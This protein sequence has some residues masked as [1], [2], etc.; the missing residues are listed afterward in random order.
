M[1]WSEL[2]CILFWRS[3]CWTTSTARWG[4][5]MFHRP[6]VPRIR[7][8]CRDTSIVMEFTSGSGETT[9]SFDAELKLQRSPVINLC[10]LC[11]TKCTWLLHDNFLYLT[12]WL[13]PETEFH[14]CEWIVEQ[15]LGGL[16]VAYSRQHEEPQPS[17][18]LSPPLP[19]SAQFP[20]QILVCDPESTDEHTKHPN[21]DPKTKKNQQLIVR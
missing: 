11:L 6:S 13:P 5:I 17:T 8:R 18:P 16:S 20:S 4:G 12:I 19:E 1:G 10:F 21:Q 14:L 2:G 7:H 15:V 9:N 3:T